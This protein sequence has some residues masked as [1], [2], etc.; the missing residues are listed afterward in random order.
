MGNANRKAI[1]RLVSQ[2]RSAEDKAKQAEKPEL[3]RTETACYIMQRT[4]R[5]FGG[6]DKDMLQNL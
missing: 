4:R 3:Q 2:I 5:Q 1:A 6:R